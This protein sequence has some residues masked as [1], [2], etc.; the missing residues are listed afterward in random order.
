MI[1]KTI[2]DKLYEQGVDV[3]YIDKW[4]SEYRLEIPCAPDVMFFTTERIFNDG[5]V[6]RQ[7]EAAVEDCEHGFFVGGGPTIEKAIENFCWGDIAKAIKQRWW[8]RN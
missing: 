5:S 2:M 1:A 3:L 7:I 6:T 8:G 4:N